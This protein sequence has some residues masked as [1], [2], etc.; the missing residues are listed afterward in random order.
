MC[1]LGWVVTLRL[2]RSMTHTGTRRFCFVTFISLN[3]FASGFTLAI[4]SPFSILKAQ[5]IFLQQRLAQNEQNHPV[6]I[7]RQVSIP[8]HDLQFLEYSI[9]F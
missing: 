5:G 6:M 4:F 2:V 9:G 1:L 3:F 8:F 7:G